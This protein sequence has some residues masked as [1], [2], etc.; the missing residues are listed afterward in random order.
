MVTLF[1]DYPPPEARPSR[2]DDCCADLHVPEGIDRIAWHYL[3]GLGH[4]RVPFTRGALCDLLGVDPDH[5]DGLWG[6]WL[7]DVECAISAAVTVGWVQQVAPEA[8]M[9][10]APELF[11]GVLPRRR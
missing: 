5:D 3:H 4:G 2:C 10:E 7:A 1:P 8:Y 9:A 6:I 11:I